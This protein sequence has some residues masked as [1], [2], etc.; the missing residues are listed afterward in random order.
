MRIICLH[1]TRSTTQFS[2]KRN[3]AEKTIVGARNIV[4]HFTNFTKLLY[5]SLTKLRRMSGDRVR[6]FL[7]ANIGVDNS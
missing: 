1:C 4:K 6:I 5:E 2:A 7:L 3:L